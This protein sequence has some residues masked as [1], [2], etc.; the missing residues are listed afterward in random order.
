MYSKKTTIS[1][2]MQTNE[3]CMNNVEGYI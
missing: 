3:I 2:L 1:L